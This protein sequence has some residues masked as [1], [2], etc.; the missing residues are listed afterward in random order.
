M[1]RGKSQ[2]SLDLIDAAKEIQPATVRVVCDVLFT[3]GLLAQ[4][5]QQ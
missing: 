4:G 3:K 1:G 5:G 2:R